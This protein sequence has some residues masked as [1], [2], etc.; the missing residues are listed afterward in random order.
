MVS[1][2]GFVA[3][4]AGHQHLAEL[5]QR[6][7]KAAAQGNDAEVRKIEVDV[8]KAAAKLWGLSEDELAEIKRSLEDM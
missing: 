7:H 6:A 4:D 8:D 1:I 5:S 3:G 2:P